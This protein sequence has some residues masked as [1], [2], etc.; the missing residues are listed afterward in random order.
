M[1]QRHDLATD[2]VAI[3]INDTAS[4]NDVLFYG[5]SETFT[6][7]DFDW[8]DVTGVNFAFVS[9]AMAI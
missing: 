4:L 5:G 6:V 1:S 2:K 3:T 9:E 7:S 8:A